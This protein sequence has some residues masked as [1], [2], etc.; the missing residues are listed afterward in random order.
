MTGVQTCAL[1]ISADEVLVMDAGRVVE[2][3]THE[4]LVA[5][6][7]RYAALWSAWSS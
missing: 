3:G 5:S 2:H 1:P 7:G 6:G 4:A